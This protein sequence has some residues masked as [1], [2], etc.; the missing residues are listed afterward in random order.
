L[1]FSLKNQNQLRNTHFFVN[2]IE[3]KKKIKEIIIK[4]EEGIIKIINGG[5]KEDKISE[6]DPKHGITMNTKIMIM[7]TIN[8]R[9]R[10]I[11]DIS[12]KKVDILKDKN[13][14]Q[15]LDQELH[16]DFKVQMLQLLDKSQNKVIKIQLFM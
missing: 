1:G 15:T 16:L 9:I 8:I 7:K 2:R 14:D 4:I 10:V 12:R 11:L 3:D 5:T 6:V 13:I